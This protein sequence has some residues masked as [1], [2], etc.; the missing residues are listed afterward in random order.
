MTKK[1]LLLSFITTLLTSCSYYK[2]ASIYSDNTK[3]IQNGL[4]FE[5]DSIKIT[6]KFWTLNGAMSFDIYNKLNIPVYFDWKKSAFIP[7]DKMKSYWQDETNTIGVSASSAYYIYGGTFGG[8]IKSK[9]KS[10]REERVGVVLP[11]SFI[12]SNKYSL[13]PPKTTFPIKTFNIS[14][15]PLRFRNYLT[16]SIFEQFDKD[17]FYIDNEFFVQSVE[18]IRR[19]KINTVKSSSAFYVNEY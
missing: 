18:K 14:N 13:V 17:V 10:I 3:Q 12:S 1:L 16:I 5:N 9:S 4:V 11:H 8:K 19:S 6:Y 2:V 7:N 15:S